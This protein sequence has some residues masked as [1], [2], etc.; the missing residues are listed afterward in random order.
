MSIT[1]AVER[2]EELAR[3]DRECVELID[4]AHQVQL[5]Q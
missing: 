5:V 2:G 3:A 1:Q 4:H